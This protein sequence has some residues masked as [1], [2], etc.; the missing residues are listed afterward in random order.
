MR[1]LAN[2]KASDG[3]T[4]VEIMIASGIL[5]VL[6]LLISTMLVNSNK[7]QKR[8]EQRASD[9]DLVQNIALNLRLHPIPSPT[10]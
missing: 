5:M 8:L 4:I 3:F 2:F 10:L 9:A 1:T 6:A 7:Q